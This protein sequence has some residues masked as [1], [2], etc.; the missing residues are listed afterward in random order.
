MLCSVRRSHDPQCRSRLRQKTVASST[1]ALSSARSHRQKQRARNERLGDEVA[2]EVV[3]G[4]AP[5]ERGPVD[6][7]VAVFAELSLDGF[8]LPDAVLDVEEL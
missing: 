5:N 2:E 3:A 6:P 1:L 7:Y 8:E 4:E